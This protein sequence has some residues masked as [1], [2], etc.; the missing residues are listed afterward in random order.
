LSATYYYIDLEKVIGLLAGQPYSPDLEPFL[1]DN[2]PCAEAAA[3]LAAIPVFSPLFPAALTCLFSPTTAIFDWRVQNLGQIKTD[4]IDFGASYDRAV[5]FGLIYAA[6]AGTYT[7]NRDRAIVPG[8]PFVELLD[9][10]GLS[11]LSL[12]ATAGAQVGNLNALA[13]LNYRDGYGIDPA[14][15][16]N[17][18]NP[19]PEGQDK[20]GSFTTVDLFFDY[21]LPEDWLDYE[22]SLS[23][24][25]TNL[26]DEDPPFYSGGGG[27]AS[28]FANGSTLGRLIQIG[29][30]TRF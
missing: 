15:P 20:V 10:P 24:N 18:A 11:D 17:P 5:D 7:L 25:V 30:R 16:A 29:L 27:G 9:S 6:L 28:G 14:V 21:R 19:F 22:V 4:G 8:A 13:S 1:R 2:V 23:L 26:F 12:V 3:E